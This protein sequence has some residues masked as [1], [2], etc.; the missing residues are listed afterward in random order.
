MECEGQG[1]PLIEKSLAWL[2]RTLTEL[3]TSPKSGD[4]Q[5]CSRRRFHMDRR[6][7]MSRWSLRSCP[8]PVLVLVGADMALLAAR[9]SSWSYGYVTP[10]P[11]TWYKRDVDGFVFAAAAGGGQGH[12]PELR[13]QPGEGDREHRFADQPGRGRH[14][15]VHVQPERGEHRRQEVRRGAMFPSSSRTTSGQVLKSGFDVVA[16]IDFDWNAMGKDVAQLHREDLPRREHRR[17]H[18]P[19]R[20]HPG[21][22]VPRILRARGR[23]SWERTRSSPCA[24]ASTIRTRR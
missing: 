24:T 4:F 10:G 23:S 1:G 9:R 3:S 21:A 22:D 16:A 20:A 8:G 14:V 18:G 17:D 13:L 6:W 15:R 2:R 5:Q 19:V 11:D 7:L 12:R